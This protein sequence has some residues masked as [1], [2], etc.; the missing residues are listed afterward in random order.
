[1]STVRGSSGDDSEDDLVN[2]GNPEFQA[3]SMYISRKGSGF[4]AA[5]VG[6]R[7][8][9]PQGLG[10]SQR[11]LT[12]GRNGGLPDERDLAAAA[13]GCLFRLLRHS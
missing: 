12:L 1:M 13:F 4:E 5:L 7:S 10:L 11:T 9:P 3:G 6:D 2:C 8:D